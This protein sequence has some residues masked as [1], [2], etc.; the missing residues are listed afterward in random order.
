MGVLNAIAPDYCDMAVAKSCCRASPHPPTS[1]P[2]SGRGGAERI[3]LR[4]LPSPLGERG[5]G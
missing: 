5:R 4:N 2:A 1:S 3:L